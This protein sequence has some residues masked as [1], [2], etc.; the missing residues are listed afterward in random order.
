MFLYFQWKSGHWGYIARENFPVLVNWIL[1]GE[2]IAVDADSLGREKKILLETMIKHHSLKL[3]AEKVRIGT[4]ILE[5]LRI[6]KKSF[7]ES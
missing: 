4:R 1:K 5:I 7:D 2:V 3:R 6:E